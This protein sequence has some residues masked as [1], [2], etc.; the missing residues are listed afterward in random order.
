MRQTDTCN[1]CLTLSI[2]QRETIAYVVETH[3]PPC[4][5]AV[6]WTTH[7]A[8]AADDDDG[9]DVHAMATTSMSNES[10]HHHC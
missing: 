7:A 4:Q 2:L 5:C 3:V 1:Q 8:A 6:G 10:F 9:D